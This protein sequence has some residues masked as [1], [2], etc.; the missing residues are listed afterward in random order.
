MGVSLTL[1]RVVDLYYSKNGLRS[2][3]NGIFESNELI[4]ITLPK[5]DKLYDEVSLFK[6]HA[7]GYG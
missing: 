6:K 2:Y 7:I 5:A 1:R 3:T 4:S